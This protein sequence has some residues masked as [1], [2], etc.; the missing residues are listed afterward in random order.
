MVD[1]SILFGTPWYRSAYCSGARIGTFHLHFVLIRQVSLCHEEPEVEIEVE[2]QLASFS[3]E[4]GKCKFSGID[5][6][7]V[8]LMLD[9]I[10]LD[11]L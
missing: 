7:R 4:R 2:S 1:C 11:R 6:T 9:R 8:Y 3:Y 10:L 5:S